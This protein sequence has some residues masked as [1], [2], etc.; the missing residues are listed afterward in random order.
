MNEIYIKEDHDRR[1]RDPGV[2]AALL[3]EGARSAGAPDTLVHQM[4]E[5]RE[6]LDKA[7]DSA[8]DGDLLLVLYEK[9]ELTLENLRTLDEII[10]A[11]AAGLLS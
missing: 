2:V 5:E 1:G 3:A 10:P 8:G 9:F 4:L 7:L 6:A 11:A